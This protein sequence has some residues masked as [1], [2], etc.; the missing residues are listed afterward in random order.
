MKKMYELAVKHSKGKSVVISE[1]GWPTRSNN[2]QIH[3]NVA[4]EYNQKVYKYVIDQWSE[5]NV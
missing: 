1:A 4:S 3:P 2:R 5:K